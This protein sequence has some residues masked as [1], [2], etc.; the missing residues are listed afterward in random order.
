MNWANKF[1]IRTMIAAGCL[2][3][4]SVAFAADVEQKAIRGRVPTQQE[5]ID[6]LAPAP[7]TR[8]LAPAS[9]GKPAARALEVDAYFDFDSAALNP[10]NKELVDNLGRALQS[11]RFAALKSITIE[12]HTDA[13]G[14]DEYNQRLSERR[15]ES[16]R[17]Y[18]VAQYKIPADKL[19]AVGK[20]KTDLK[21]KAAPFAGENRRVN[22]ITE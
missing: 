21:N 14:S 10:R 1:G 4:M 3:A 20:G 5:I 7:K 11:E 6:A 12:G 19:K 2:A 8:G 9:A 13:K 18:L 17:T 15:A 16:V 22:I